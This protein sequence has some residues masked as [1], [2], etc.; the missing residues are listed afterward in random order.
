MKRVYP[1][2]APDS[3]RRPLAELPPHARVV[4]LFLHDPDLAW[5]PLLSR[6]IPRDDG[7]VRAYDLGTVAELERSIV[8][9]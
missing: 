3:L 4:V 5:M 9:P 1:A 8:G 7:V 6:A 2:T